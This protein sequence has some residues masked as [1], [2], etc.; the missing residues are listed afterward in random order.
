MFVCC[1]CC[2]LSG[3]GLCNELITH[4]EETHRVLCVVVCDLETSWMG[5]SWP[6]GGG[7]GAVAPKTNKQKLLMENDRQILTP[8]NENL[9]SYVMLRST[10][11]QVVTDVSEQPTGTIFGGQT[12]Q[13]YNPWIRFFPDFSSLGRWDPKN[14]PDTSLTNYQSTMHNI[15][16]TAKSPHHG[17]SLKSHWFLIKNIVQ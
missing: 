3:R 13:F 5:R 11:W 6:T 9:R 15:P 7:G 17:F 10:V 8:P 14:Y 2:V 12:V 4:P 16:R 1:E